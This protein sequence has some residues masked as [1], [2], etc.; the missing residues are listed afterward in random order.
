MGKPARRL[1][2]RFRAA[3]HSRDI[4]EVFAV[5]N[6]NKPNL[7]RDRVKAC[8]FQDRFEALLGETSSIDTDAVSTAAPAEEIASAP[9]PQT[10]ELE[11]LTFRHALNVCRK[12]A[13]SIGK[14]AP[15]AF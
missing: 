2:L 1:R 12:I 15:E 5:G 9:D 13:H 4:G 3:P 8:L 14:F 10:A 6:S 7:A 11:A